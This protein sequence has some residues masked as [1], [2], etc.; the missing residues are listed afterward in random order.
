MIEHLKTASEGRALTDT[1][2]AEAMEVIMSG[3]AS[4]ARTGAF[5]AALAVRGETGAE[6]T[7]AARVLRGK[8]LTIAAPEGTLD[9]CGTG[10]DGAGTFNIST[11]VAL[12]TA[13]CG[14]PV[15]K[16]GNRAASSRSGTADVLEKLGVRLEL[17]PE[18]LEEALRRFHFC[19][20]MAPRHHAAMK[21][22]SAVRKE[23]GF[24]TIFNLLGPLANPAGTKRQL[25]GVYDRKWLLPIA[26]AL[27]DLGSE[28]ALIVHGSDGLDE[29]TLTGPTFAARLED[30]Q[31]TEVTLTPEDFDLPGCRAGDL[32][33]GEPNE[34][35]QALTRMLEGEPGAYRDIVLANTA[36]ALSVHGGTQSLTDAA[37]QAAQAIDSGAALRLLRDYAHFTREA[38]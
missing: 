36:A 34:N 38:G 10:G 3:G 9:C 8:A 1:Q 5:L 33:G 2:M 13:A 21:H 24:R 7:G 37:R 29:I 26:E 30:G 31:I 35:A 20:L 12:V 22:V 32:R 15:A 4:A 19:F 14:V 6:I 25:I 11:A 17:P 28:R 16:H 23:L 27:R 18:K